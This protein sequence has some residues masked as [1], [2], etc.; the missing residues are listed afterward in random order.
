MEL[1]EALIEENAAARVVEI[2][3]RET[4][5]ATKGDF[6]GSVTGIWVELGESGLGIVSYNQKQYRTRP[7]GFTSIAAGQ[8]VFLSYAA[9]V[10]YSN[11]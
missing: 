10:Y 6:E 9:G 8:P 11:W 5:P 2:E 3:R 1:L 4:G 7:L